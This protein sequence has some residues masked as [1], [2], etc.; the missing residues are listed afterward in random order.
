MRDVATVIK[1]E[2]ACYH[3][4]YASPVEHDDINVRLFIITQI[5]TIYVWEKT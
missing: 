1:C 4:A 3:W 2:S 5:V